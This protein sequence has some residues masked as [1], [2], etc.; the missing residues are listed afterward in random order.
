MPKKSKYPGLRART[1]VAPSGK[2][3]TGYYYCKHGQKHEIALGT[4]WEEALSEWKRLHLK[5]PS[6]RAL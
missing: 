2:V 1:R 4:N 3:W 5:E 6:Q